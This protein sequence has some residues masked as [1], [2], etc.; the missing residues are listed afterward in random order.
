MKSPFLQRVLAT[1]A[2][3]PVSKVVYQSKFASRAANG[4]VR[5]ETETAAKKKNDLLKKS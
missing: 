2:S 1:V 4:V 3:E 5:G